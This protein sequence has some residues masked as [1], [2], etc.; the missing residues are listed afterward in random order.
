MY[1]AVVILA[2]V[3][4]FLLLLLKS[5]TV[6]YQLLYCTCYVQVNELNTANALAAFTQHNV[7]CE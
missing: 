2:T 3:A 5:V 4:N 6:L 7:N 1:L